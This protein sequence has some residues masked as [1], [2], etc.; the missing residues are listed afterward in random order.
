VSE[1]REPG[2]VARSLG[3]DGRGESMD[4]V[5]PRIAIVLAAGRSERLQSV[6]GGGSKAL[7]RLGGLA[8]VQRTVLSLLS[9]G[10]EHVVVVTG[11]HAGPVGA[12]IDRIAPGRVRAIYA[13]GWEAG[14]GASLAAAETVVGLEPSFIVMTAD[15]LFG[16]GAFEELMSSRPPACLMDPSPEADVW[17]EGTRVQLI[18]ERQAWAFG[19]EL[20]EPAVDCGVFVLTPEVFESQRQAGDHDFTLA[21]ALTRLAQRQPFEA[22]PLPEGCWW[23]DVDTPTDL[24]IARKRLRQSLGKAEDGPVSRYL[25]RPLSTRLSMAMAPLRPNPNLISVGVMLIGLLAAGLLG[26]GMG[27][28]GGVL[29]QA[30]SILD[31][32][33]GELARLQL[34]AGPLGALLDGVLD[35]IVDAAVLGG[36][37]VWGLRGSGSPGLILALTVAATAGSVLSMATKDRVR[38]LGLPAAPE[39]PIAFL[40][41]GRDGRL[42]LLALFAVL[43]LPVVAL[44]AVTATSWLSMT[45]RV[46]VVRRRARHAAVQAQRQ[47]APDPRA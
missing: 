22:V 12:V 11:Y 47:V 7:I 45:V 8:I 46:I 27:V 1:T 38:A 34:R 36:L 21:G 28:A 44:L 13:E 18:G 16:D 6:T 4:A 40:L 42:L 23:Q 32:V 35:R 37:G 5:Q 25:N 30:A 33:D 9:Y 31:G 24:G 26:L 17:A 3:L 15:H 43:G 19:K 10:L 20:D 41:G 2:G 39:G 29:T 14:N